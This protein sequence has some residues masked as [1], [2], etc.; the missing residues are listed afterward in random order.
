MS[1]EGAHE[2]G[3]QAYY[4]IFNILILLTLTTVAISYVNFVNHAG[5]IIAAMCVAIVK[6]TLVL[7]FFMH[8]KYEGKL[9]RYT[10]IFALSLFGLAVTVFCVD[11]LWLG[12]YEV[13]HQVGKALVHH[14]GVD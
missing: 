10:A 14:A 3:W 9:N 2:P 1:K 5:N 7:L 12:T 6:A 13:S 4:M 8:Q 11:F